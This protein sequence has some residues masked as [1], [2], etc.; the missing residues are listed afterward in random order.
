[1]IFVTTLLAAAVVLTTHELGHYLAARALRAPVT[2]VDIGYGPVLSVCEK[3]G[4]RW[5]LRILPLGGSVVYPAEIRQ[6]PNIYLTVLIAGPLANL[7]TGAIV[8]FFLLTF[9][10]MPDVAELSASSLHSFLWMYAGL[11]LAIGIF[12]LLPMPP[13]DGASIVAT[14]ISILTGRCCRPAGQIADGLGVAII[15]FSTLGF[16]AW[17]AWS[18]LMS[19]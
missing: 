18:V 19:P 5:T 6:S 7:L 12:N 2:S 14:T 16:G 8:G 11:S 1:M 10:L 15:R 13:L 3:T 4:V 17:V 9:G